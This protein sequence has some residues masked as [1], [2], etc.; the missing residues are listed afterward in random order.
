MVP[1]P[2]V[3]SDPNAWLRSYWADLHRQPFFANLAPD[4]QAA[5]LADALE[6]EH[7][8]KAQEIREWNRATRLAMLAGLDQG[9]R[10]RHASREVVLWT[11][12]KRERQLTCVAVYL[13]TG[14]DLRLMECGEMRRTEL[15]SW[16]HVLLGRAR[17]WQAV[18]AES[19]WG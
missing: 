15:F 18:L 4:L 14:I 10:E 6:R 11:V 16:G 9:L 17:R 5:A 3:L 1:D 8:A 2:L 12:R 7:P 13:P 19:G